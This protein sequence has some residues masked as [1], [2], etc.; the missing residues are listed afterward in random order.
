MGSILPWRATP[1]GETVL[2]QFIA[3]FAGLEELL[4]TLLLKGTI[5]TT[6]VLN[7]PRAIAQQI[8]DQC[9]D[10]ALALKLSGSSRNR[11]TPRFGASAR[12]GRH[13]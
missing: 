4:E 11:R 6:D 5:V 2:D 1:A 13:C 8:V 12:S 7:C 3:R 9:G 10:Y